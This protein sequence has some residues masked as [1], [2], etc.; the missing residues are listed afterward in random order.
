MCLFFGV[1]F[2]LDR[3]DAF[4][5]QRAH[6][7]PNLAKLEKKKVPDCQAK[8]SFLADKLESVGA[9]GVGD[10]VRY[11]TAKVLFQG[12]SH[13][14]IFGEENGLQLL[15]DRERWGKGKGNSLVQKRCNYKPNTGP[16][17]RLFSLAPFAPGGGGSPEFRLFFGSPFPGF[18]GLM[19]DMTPTLGFVL[20]FLLKFSS[21]F[22]S[23]CG[24]G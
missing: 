18:L 12:S 5:A 23:S 22:R 2:R 20:N 6:C 19:T 24:K 15:L 21:R 16:L 13:T 17:A 3:V 8:C 10:Y 7:V 9:I 14:N 11:T 4:R 1:R